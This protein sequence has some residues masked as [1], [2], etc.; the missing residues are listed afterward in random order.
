MGDGNRRSRGRPG[1]SEQAMK[2]LEPQHAAF[3]LDLQFVVTVE[4]DVVPAGELRCTVENV[5]FDL[6]GPSPKLGDTSYRAQ[7]MRYLET[8]LIDA[9][10]DGEGGRLCELA[11]IEE[12]RHE[13]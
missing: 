10:V 7:L 1:E 12:A 2:T 8:W 3:I 13:R 5:E 4:G 9:L 6:S 11:L